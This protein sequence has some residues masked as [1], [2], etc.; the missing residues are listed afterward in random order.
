[1]AGAV[2]RVASGMP[3]M[4]PPSDSG[5][6]AIGGY[7]ENPQEHWA[8]SGRPIYQTSRCDILTF[9][10]SIQH[11]AAS[12]PLLGFHRHAWASASANAL[13]KPPPPNDDCERW[14]SLRRLLYLS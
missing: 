13:F 14:H 5:L 3:V 12:L 4:V 10:Y 6:E 8:H 2:I 1:V 11:C 7:R 9:T